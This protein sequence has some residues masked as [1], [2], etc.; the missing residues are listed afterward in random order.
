MTTVMRGSDNFDTAENGRVL[1]VVAVNG[2]SSD[3]NTT[4]STLVQV[5]DS[6]ISITPTSS[7]SRIYVTWQLAPHIFLLLLVLTQ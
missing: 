6:S 4:S 5:D 7:S 3:W 1:Q 2:R